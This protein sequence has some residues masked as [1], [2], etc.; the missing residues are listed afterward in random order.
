MSDILSVYGREVVSMP[1]VLKAGGWL[2]ML[3][4]VVS[5]S[6]LAAFPKPVGFV[7]DF[8]QVIN[9][10][11]SIEMDSVAKALQDSRGVEMAIVTINSSEPITPKEYATQLFNEWGI[12]G[13][14]DSGLLILLA[15]EEREIQVEV[16]YGLEGVLPDGKV[17]GILDEAVIPYFAKGD[18]GR[19]LLEGAR[20][21]KAE[22]AE[23]SYARR[24][25]DNSGLWGFVIFLVIVAI[26]YLSKARTPAGPTGPSGPVG[27]GGTVSRPRPVYRPPV[28]RGPRGGS[29]GF[30]GFGGG[31]SGGG[32]AGR[33]F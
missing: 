5:V 15:M 19:G 9:R 25:E 3:L 32:G 30:G 21:F 26:I 20:A 10:S 12:G 27:P 23:E 11:Y 17:G 13:P 2:L 8:A 22:L 1:K 29:G 16:G 6:C 31:R 4:L 14:E 18:Y 28:S 24:K 33:K 7:N